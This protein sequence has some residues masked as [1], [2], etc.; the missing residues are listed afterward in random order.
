MQARDIAACVEIVAS[1]PVIGSRYGSTI[2]DL[3]FAWSRGLESEA[4]Q[5]LV[6]EEAEGSH[7][8]ECGVGVAVFV[9][10]DFMN[11]LKSRPFWIGPELTRRIAS[12]ES[13]A[14]S[15]RQLREDNTRGGLNLVTWE[16]IARQ[17]FEGRSELQ[18][19]FA[20][21]FIEIHKGFF[22]KEAI[23]SQA[24]NVERFYWTME[25]GAFLWNF[26]SACYIDRSQED[27]IKIIGKPHVL[28][29]SREIEVRRPGTWVGTLFEY[30]P[31]KIGL[32]RA[33]QQLVMAA[34]RNMSSTDQN[35]ADALNV[36]VPTVKKTWL[37]IYRRA[38]TCLPRVI[39]NG[40]PS[41]FDSA[42]RGKERKRQI[43]SYVR[44]HP[45]ELRPFSRKIL[46]ISS[47]L[48]H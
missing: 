34:L 31:P 3:S 22:L 23:A 14:L 1:H 41:D 46:D 8:T 10:D 13:P 36:S 32:S 4:F 18:R 9:H 35:L 44:E 12:G 2:S 19:A 25:S 17:G 42:Q 20:T 33:E 26:G 21:S 40:T 7:V 28:G 29:I 24:E 30:S 6:F 48:S 45:E 38:S 37:S 5:M 15:D 43:L 11:E 47:L 16:G 39:S 27:P